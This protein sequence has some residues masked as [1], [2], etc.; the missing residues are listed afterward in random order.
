MFARHHKGEDARGGVGDNAEIA[1]RGLDAFVRLSYEEARRLCTPDVELWTLF[2]QP[3]H[4]PQFDGIEG[5]G[6]WFER[7]REL[8]AFIDVKGVEL[9]EREGGW[10]LMRVDA[11]LRGRGS[12]HELEPRI[13]VAI[14]VADR[15]IARLGL[16]AS[17]AGAVGMIEG[18]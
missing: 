1:R 14:Q 18:K 4:E 6:R 3:G 10:M 13:S 2:D 11:R 16:F 8:W 5:L 7:L 12:P 15:R 9:S 17:E